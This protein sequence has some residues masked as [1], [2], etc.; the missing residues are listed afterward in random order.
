MIHSL[1]VAL[2]ARAPDLISAHLWIAS[3][4]ALAC[5]AMGNDAHSAVWLLCFGDQGWAVRSFTGYI[6]FWLRY[7]NY[8][9]LTRELLLMLVAMMAPA[10]T[11]PFTH[12]WYRSLS[13][14]RVRALVL[15]LLGY[16]FVWLCASSL[17]LA[18]AI[19]LVTVT[20]SA[21]LAS[22][23]C[24]IVAVVWKMSRAR[25]LC[26]AHCH[27][28]ARLSIFGLAALIDPIRFGITHAFWCIGTCWTLMLVLY[29]VPYAHAITMLFGTMVVAQ[30]RAALRLL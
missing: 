13:R 29:C 1:K 15:F 25:S 21:I 5:I 24:A 7:T 8:P 18:A 27:Q 9:V 11:G 19:I 28:R 6:E 26:L 4:A 3:F 14:H 16:S 12:L 23:L 22:C 2:H 20:G 10:L 17:L 30:E